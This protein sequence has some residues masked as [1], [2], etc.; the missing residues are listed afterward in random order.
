MIHPFH[1]YIIKNMTYSYLNYHSYHLSQWVHKQRNRPTFTK[2]RKKINIK[3]TYYPHVNFIIPGKSQQTS[4]ISERTSS[5]TFCSLHLQILQLH[6]KQRIRQS[7]SS[8]FQ[9]HFNLRT[10][11]SPSY[12]SSTLFQAKNTPITIFQFFNPTSSF[13]RYNYIL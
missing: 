10:L 1:G 7:P 2:Y 6:F 5:F 3:Q 4:T 13:A 8:N 9:L 12:S 11:R